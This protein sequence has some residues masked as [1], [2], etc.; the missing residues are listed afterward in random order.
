M[1]VKPLNYMSTLN[2]LNRNIIL[3]TS[4]FINS[5][6]KKRVRMNRDVFVARFSHFLKFF[7]QIFGFQI[8]ELQNNILALKRYKQIYSHLLMA[9]LMGGIGY[10]VHERLQMPLTRITQYGIVV[11]ILEGSLGI[12]SLFYDANI[13]TYKKTGTYK[14]LTEIDHIQGMT[15]TQRS[16]MIVNVFVMYVIYLVYFVFTTIYDYYVWEYTF[17]DVI[18]L[19]RSAYVDLATLYFATEL[20]MLMSRLRLLN[21]NLKRIY[22]NEILSMK[23][24]E[25]FLRWKMMPREST[26]ANRIDLIDIMA[27][28]GKLEESAKYVVTRFE[29]T[30]SFIYKRTLHYINIHF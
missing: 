8:A 27:I 7:Y 22:G 14:R 4:N 30:V 5:R 28:Y 15:T 10:D 13:S 1:S 26:N 2:I 29:K 12:F 19:T 24:N 6:V 11:T 25:D 9:V 16:D 20:V 23:T 17:A 3:T 18:S 21:C